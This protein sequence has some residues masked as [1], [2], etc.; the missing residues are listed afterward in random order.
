MQQAEVQT[1]EH[2]NTNLRFTVHRR[3]HCVVELDIEAFE[4]LV[5]AARQLAIKAIAKEVTLPGFRKGKAPN[6]LIVKN[7]PNELDKE[8][9]QK[10]ADAAFAEGLK[11]CNI[12]LLHKDPRITYKMKSHSANGA[13]LSLT[14]ETEPTVPEVDP[15]AMQLKP[16][17]RPS[18]DE[19][20]IN[21]TIRQ[22]QLFFA[23]WS[24]VEDRP[25]QEGDFV[26]LDVDVIE[27]TPHTPLFSHTRFEV[28]DKSMA[29]W[30]L[31]LVLGKNKGDTVEGISVP[32]ADASEEDKEELK[33]KKVRVTI[34]DVSTAKL[35]ELTND[36]ASKLGVDS[37]EKMRENITELLNKQADAHV[38]EAKREQASEFLL[39]EYAFDLPQTLVE[40]EAQFRFRQLMQDP[41][42]QK[43]WQELPQE[44]QKKTAMTI[45]AQS[46]KAVRMF[47]LCRKIIAEAKIKISAEDVQ[48]AAT[49]ALEMLLDPQKMFHHQKNPEAEHAEAFSRL[50]LEKAEDYVV[51]NASQ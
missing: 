22:I 43:Y 33:P 8:W 42:F 24:H 26:L 14:F 19:D 51:E 9:Q 5:S 41:D 36:F 16:V 15:K 45:Y 38:L 39:K 35:P 25:V 7:Y 40:K 4:P 34:R 29:K 27:E 11:L 37:L 31:D 12:P 28:K 32:D 20:K 47:Y 21:E 46:E 2:Q 18:T 17:K 3:P 49:S 50:V 23:E 10:I 44:E 13:L 48:P 30:M 6:E 1:Q